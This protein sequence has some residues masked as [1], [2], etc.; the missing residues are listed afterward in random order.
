VCAC[1]LP[2]S[3]PIVAGICSEI[4]FVTRR[5]NYGEIAQGVGVKRGMTKSGDD[6]PV[7]IGC[8]IRHGRN[9]TLM[10]T[11]AQN[12]CGCG[13]CECRDGRVVLVWWKVCGMMVGNL[14][15]ETTPE[16]SHVS[17]IS[18]EGHP[19]KLGLFF[20]SK[21]RTDV[22][23]IYAALLYRVLISYQKEFQRQFGLCTTSATAATSADPMIIL[24][25]HL[26]RS[27]LGHDSSAPRTTHR[28]S[29]E[30]RRHNRTDQIRRKA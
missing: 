20:S 16:I 1:A 12:V 25:Q 10:G 28:H 21:N 8:I 3:R 15:R 4:R 27:H 2:S 23:H 30:N 13:Y 5:L 14:G 11:W 22:K 29:A 26:H 7:G 18:P 17:A 6:G 19:E 24:L 9:I